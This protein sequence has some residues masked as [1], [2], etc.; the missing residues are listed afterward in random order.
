MYDIAQSLNRCAV[1]HFVLL[2][3][4]INDHLV[5]NSQFI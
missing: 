3:E 5:K 1:Q 4:Y 2:H